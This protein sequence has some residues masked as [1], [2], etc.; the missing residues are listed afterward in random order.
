MT[1][2]RRLR[3][4]D[5]L[6]LADDHA[7]GYREARQAETGAQFGT[8]TSVRNLD[9]PGLAAAQKWR[10]MVAVIARGVT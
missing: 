8:L 5:H 7:A 10:P 4:A 2:S 1:L 9:L 6:D 3:S